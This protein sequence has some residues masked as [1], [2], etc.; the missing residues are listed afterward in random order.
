MKLMRKTIHCIALVVFATS[1]L[2]VGVS[3]QSQTGPS[4]VHVPESGE[5]KL[6]DVPRLGEEVS[7]ALLSTHVDRNPMQQYI[8][9]TLMCLVPGLWECHTWFDADGTGVQFHARKKPD[10][11]IELGSSAFTYRLAGTPGDYHLCLKP[12]GSKQETCEKETWE[13]GHYLYD[14][15][16][17]NYDRPAADGLPAYKNVH[18]QYA[19]LPRHQ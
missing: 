7:G 3:V 10:G 8:G 2:C 19:I 14:E 16:F 9:N 12:S 15:W 18:E 4:A 1:C 17:N 5:I 11:S 13:E 6:Q